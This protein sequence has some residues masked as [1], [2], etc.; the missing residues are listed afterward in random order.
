MDRFRSEF[1]LREDIYSVDVSD[2]NPVNSGDRHAALASPKLSLIFGPWARTELYLQ[3]GYGF[4]SNDAR[5]DT[6]TVNPDDSV[7]GTHLPVL[8]PARGAE[9]GI[10][11]TAANELQSTLSL[12]YLHN[13]SELYFNGI[14]ADSGITTASQQAT[15]RYGVEF[16]NYFRPAPWLAF[17]LDYADSWAHFVSPTTAAEDIAPGG[18]LVDEAIR[19][20]LSSGVTVKNSG[21]WEASLRLRYFGPRPLTSTGSVKSDSTLILNLGMGWRINRT[22][23]VTADILNLLDRRDHDIDYYYQSRNSPAP[24]SPAPDEIHFHAVEPLEFRLGIEAT[25]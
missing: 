2:L 6:A 25:L 13:D 16:A 11:T 20:S 10:R 1:G 7:V 8:V 18:T 22:W 12:W 5:A 15:N 17:D 14:D 23:K 24:G 9:F 4:H 21:G 3:A 19:Q